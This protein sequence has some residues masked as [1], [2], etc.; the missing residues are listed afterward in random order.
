MKLTNLTNNCIFGSNSGMDLNFYLTTVPN[1]I[2]ASVRVKFRKE[3]IL[4][5]MLSRNLNIIVNSE[6]HS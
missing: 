3:L 4:I 2:K 5:S 1:Q 6:L